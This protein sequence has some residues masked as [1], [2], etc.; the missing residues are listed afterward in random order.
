MEFVSLP[1]SLAKVMPENRHAQITEW[2]TAKILIPR[3]SYAWKYIGEDY[4]LVNE[5]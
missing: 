2:S 4:Q 3:L 1:K 5:Y